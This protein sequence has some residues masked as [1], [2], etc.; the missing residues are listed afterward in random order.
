MHLNEAVQNAQ[1][2]ETQSYS[3]GS[4]CFCFATV[5]PLHGLTLRKPCVILNVS[6]PPTPNS[7]VE[8]LTP[9]VMAFGGETFGR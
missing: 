7:Y 9:N 2:K 4:C 6:V 3:L 1:S 8:I 5:R